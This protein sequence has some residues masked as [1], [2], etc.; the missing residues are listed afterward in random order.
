MK[1]AI[2]RATADPAAAAIPQAFRLYLKAKAENRE[3]AD[4]ADDAG[5]SFTVRAVLK[6]ATSVMTTTDTSTS[7]LIDGAVSAWSDALRQRSAFAAAFADGAFA[8]VPFLIRST[9]ITNGA[10]ASVVGE[11]RPAPISRIDF[12]AAQTLQPE[13]I[14]AT[15]AVTGELMDEASREGSALL[16][17]ELNR[18][19]ATCLDEAM[20]ARIVNTGTP[21]FSSAGIADAAHADLLDLIGSLD[22]D[23]GSRIYAVASADVVRGAS[24][25]WTTYGGRVF[26]NV[27]VTGGTL[28]G[29]IP[30]FLSSAMEPGEMLV[31]DAGRIGANLGAPRFEVARHASIEMATDPSNDA[32]SPSETTTVNLWQA[33][34]RAARI[35]LTFGCK[36]ERENVAALMTGIA[37]GAT[38]SPV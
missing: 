14:Q 35:S 2:V 19:V 13:K 20:V 22:P 7:V 1:A 31:F 24:L 37:W 10:V 3:P 4:I 36:P 25:L 16:E 6:A 9:V 27:S 18:A 29:G 30:L 12:S 33:G 5:A 26:P 21:S 32:V 17:R 23:E 34:L 15:V 8:R 11:G 28:P 38:G